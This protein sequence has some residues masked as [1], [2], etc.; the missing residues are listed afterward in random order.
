MTADMSMGIRGNP[1]WRDAKTLWKC[2][3]V[4]DDISAMRRCVETSSH[5]PFRRYHMMMLTSGLIVQHFFLNIV[6]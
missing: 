4:I 2:I 3:Q 5:V 1:A 6:G